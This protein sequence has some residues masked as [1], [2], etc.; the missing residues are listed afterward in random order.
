VSWQ[1]T[2]VRQDPFAEAHRIVPE[3]SKAPQERGR[4][5]HPQLHGQPAALRVTPVPGSTPPPQANALTGAFWAVAAAAEPP[6]PA[7]ASGDGMVDVQDL[8]IVIVAWG[9]CA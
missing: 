6:C 4:Y 2:G 9:P 7:D 1:V 3:E 5:L 8:V